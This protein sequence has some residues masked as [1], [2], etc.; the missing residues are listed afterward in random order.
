MFGP[1]VIPGSTSLGGTVGQLSDSRTVPPDCIAQSLALQPTTSQKVSQ[2]FKRG[3]QRRR[4]DTPMRRNESFQIVLLEFTSVP[5]IQSTD[6]VRLKQ[7][8]ATT[9][10]QHIKRPHVLKYSDGY[11]DYRCHYICQQYLKQMQPCNHTA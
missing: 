7:F 10:V 11:V 9:S 5:H 8:S 2:A 1:P 6:R 4:N 3:G